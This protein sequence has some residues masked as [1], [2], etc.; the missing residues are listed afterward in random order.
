MVTIA[1]VS[2]LCVPYHSDDHL[3]D[4]TVSRPAGRELPRLVPELPAADIWTRLGQL[5]DAV[6]DVVERE[7]RAG[8]P[9]T[10]VS[11]DCMV[12]IGM[13]AGLQRAGVDPA[14]VWFDAHGDLQTL[15]TTTSGYLGGLALRHL[16]GYRPE[17]LSGRLGL[18]ATPEERVLLVGARD[19]DPPE[20]DHL[21]AGRIRQST[22]EELSAELLPD[23]PL[24]V[25][26]DLDVIDPDELPGL[27][28]PASGGPGRATVLRAA[29]TVLDTGRVAA[30]NVACTWVTGSA[31]RDGLRAELVTALLDGR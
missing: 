15:E 4:L 8:E 18:R 22:V 28:Y 14:I 6:A 20:V 19:L 12:S 26:L 5:Y 2:T 1:R 7:A 10:V 9:A 31:D 27:R 3:P 13:A 24:L 25:N 17:L 16:L 11:G 29:R 30:L 21:A 23:G